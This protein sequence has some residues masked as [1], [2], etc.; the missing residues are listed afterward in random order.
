MSDDYHRKIIDLGTVCK[1]TIRARVQPPHTMYVY[2][3]TGRIG[4]VTTPA[5]RYLRGSAYEARKSY[6]DEHARA[7]CKGT[8]QIRL[9]EYL[10]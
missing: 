4:Y 2:D 5:D 10:T 9:D 7:A 3:G 8:R 1:G 6:H